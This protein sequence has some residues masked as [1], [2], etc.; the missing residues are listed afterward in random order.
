MKTL[1]VSVLLLLSLSLS[2]LNLFLEVR[3]DAWLFEMHQEIMTLKDDMEGL[4]STTT[5][6]HDVW[7]TAFNELNDDYSNAGDLIETSDSRISSLED[8]NKNLR[9]EIDECVVEQGRLYSEISNTVGPL[10]ELFVQY[11]APEITKREKM[12]VEAKIAEE[13]KIIAE[14][15]KREKEKKSE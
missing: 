2:A 15:A 1:I 13:A 11:A 7:Q 6:Y 5:S 8:A 9:Q 12:A 14:E 4:K 3:D 10:A